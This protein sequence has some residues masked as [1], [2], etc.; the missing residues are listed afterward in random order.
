MPNIKAFWLTSFKANNKNQTWKPEIKEILETL[1]SCNADGLDCNAN[2]EVLTPSFV[3]AIREAGYELHCW[4]VNQA[5][6]ARKLK[7]F[8]VD[9]ITTDRPQWLRNQIE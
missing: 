7:A 2:L 1:K 8:P 6:V 4:T 9:S 5:D 3:D